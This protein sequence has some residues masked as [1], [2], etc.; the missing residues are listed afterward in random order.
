MRRQGV[1]D[2]RLHGVRVLAHEEITRRDRRSKKRFKG[3]E[4]VGYHTVLQVMLRKVVQ[5]MNPW[6]LLKT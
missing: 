3:P 1:I 6:V 2:L 4:T 5:V